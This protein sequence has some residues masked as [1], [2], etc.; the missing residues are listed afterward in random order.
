MYQIANKAQDF[1][2]ERDICPSVRFGNLEVDETTNQEIANIYQ[3][4][5]NKDP[6]YP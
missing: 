3:Q 2:D 5:F 6:E 4:V 1:Q